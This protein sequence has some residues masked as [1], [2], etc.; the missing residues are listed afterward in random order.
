MENKILIR[1]IV[2]DD[3]HA[4][5]GI[6]R[7]SL[8]EFNANKPGTVYFDETTDHLSE[9]FKRENSAYFVLL[10]DDEI[11]GG[12]G[13]YPTAGLPA[14]TC[15]LVKMYL[16]GKFRQKGLGYL[17]LKKCIEEA[18]QSGYKRMYIETMPELK[19]AIALYQKNGFHFINAPLG[20][21]GHTGCD[22]W[23]LKDL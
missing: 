17:L 6:I 7:S 4:L 9:L 19:K 22:V 10:I 18:R 5:A 13:F 11:A 12:G 16:S 21:S 1:K 15:E 3:N 2:T 8:K 14:K 23:M 20:N